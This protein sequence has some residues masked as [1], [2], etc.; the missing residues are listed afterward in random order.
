MSF[1]FW[2]YLDYFELNSILCLYLKGLIGGERLVCFYLFK[3]NL[4][5][6]IV[7][8]WNKD[9]NWYWNYEKLIVCYCDLF[10]LWDLEGLWVSCKIIGYNFSFFV[11]CGFEL[12]CEFVLEVS[13][14]KSF[15]YFF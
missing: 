6:K 9:I 2:F 10:V 15:F 1:F 12:D 7:I 11:V 8:S 4:L 14:G 13:F 3:R 5:R